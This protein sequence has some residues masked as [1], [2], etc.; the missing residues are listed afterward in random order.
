MNRQM[1]SSSDRTMLNPQREHLMI[2]IWKKDVLVGMRVELCWPVI[3]ALQ[4]LGRDHLGTN[5]MGN[6]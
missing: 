3:M 4:I 5:S 1:A 6:P 2:S